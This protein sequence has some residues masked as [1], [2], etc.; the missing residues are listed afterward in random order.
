MLQFE[1][2]IDHS[3]VIKVIGVGGGGCNAVNRMIEAGLKGVQFIA[4][5]TDRQALNKCA[6]ENKIQI[7]EKLTR[8]LGAGGNPRMGQESAQETI[9]AISNAVEGADMVFIT[10]GMGGGTGT[11]AAPIIAK[12]S[13]D[14]GI[15]TVAVVTKPFTFEGR[16]RLK[17]AEQGLGYLKE[18]VDSLVIVPN[19]RLLEI[20]DKNTTM[21]EAFGMA[22]DVLRQGV[23]GITDIISDFAVIN[24]DFADVKS[25][26]TD[27]G[28][29]HMGVGH[30]NGENR[31]EEAVT[32]AIESP[33]LETTISGAGA[34][35]LYI[36]GREDLSM[37]EINEM[38][39]MVQDQVD[40]DAIFI[41]GAAVC[42]DL[43]D[44]ISI[45][46]IATGFAN[47]QDKVDFRPA[48]STVGLDEKKV[49]TE[50]G[51][52]GRE[53]TLGDIFDHRT[54]TADEDSIFGIPSFLKK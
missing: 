14:M 30:G 5:N 32:Q 19:D 7:G 35:L 27:R 23:Q 51:L 31:A 8:G 52:T 17:Q 22:D 29:A 11:G 50:E 43:K 2:E 6:A 16:K 45:T 44:D 53:V 24:T 47:S 37:L 15:L 28:I 40:E 18:F 38:A 26:M 39:S 1:T 49:T 13:K 9:E 41:F 46:V 4:I 3:A 34:V 10:A 12:V 54:S 20:S 36:A 21:I 25:V 33:L 42:E 48:S